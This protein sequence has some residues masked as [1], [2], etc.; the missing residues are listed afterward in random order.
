[1]NKTLLVVFTGYRSRLSSFSLAAGMRAGILNFD[2]QRDSVFLSIFVDNLRVNSL[3]CGGDVLP[4]STIELKHTHLS[5]YLCFSVIRTQ[6]HISSQKC[7]RHSDI[8]HRKGGIYF[9]NLRYLDHSLAHQEQKVGHIG[10]SSHLLESTMW[11]YLCFG[12][13]RDI[14]LHGLTTHYTDV[15]SFCVI[16][17]PHN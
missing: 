1:M 17:F 14:F 16:A 10:L 11:K 4:S 12:R 6:L 3:W 13:G 15:L 7:N 9:D 8:E 2:S 5:L